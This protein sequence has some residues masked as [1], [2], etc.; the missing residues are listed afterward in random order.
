MRVAYLINQYPKT[1][2]TFI[3]RE[4]QALERAGTKIVRISIRGWNDPLVDSEDL[5]ERQKTRYVL[6]AGALALLLCLLKSALI[7]PVLFTRALALAVRMGWRAE[8]P[9]PVHIIYLAE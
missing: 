3:R 8:R 1:S 7:R 4:I 6:R 9:L 2:H 5:A